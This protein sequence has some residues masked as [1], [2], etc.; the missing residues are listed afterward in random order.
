MK[1]RLYTYAMI[2]LLVILFTA[3][4][5]Q[6]FSP[7][8]TPGQALR[9]A[10]NWLKYFI[11]QKGSWGGESSASIG[12]MHVIMNDSDTLG[13][14]F[15]ILPHGY[16]LCPAYN[17]QVPILAYSTSH[18]LTFFE[19]RS[20]GSVLHRVLQHRLK[21]IQDLQDDWQR[22]DGLGM[23]PD[24][25][26]HQQ[27]LWEIYT[28]EWQIFLE[29]IKSGQTDDFGPFLETHWH[30][31]DPY[32]QMCPMGAVGRCFVGCTALATAQIMK[33]YN[34]PLSGVNNPMPSYY[35]PGEPPTV[36]GQ[37][38]T[39]DLSD[40]YDWANMLNSYGTS[41]TQIQQDAVSELCYEIGVALE[42]IYRSQAPGSSAFPDDVLDVMSEQFRYSS[43]IIGEN[44]SSYS[45]ADDW[46]QMLQVELNAYRPVHYSFWEETPTEWGHS[47]VCDGW[48]VNGDLNQIH[49]NWG[50]GGE[51]DDWYTIDGITSIPLEDYAVHNIY[52]AGTQVSGDVTGTWTLQNSPYLVTGHITVPANQSL[53]IEPGVEVIFQGHYKFNVSTNATLTAVGTEQDSI[54]FTA[55]NPTTGWWGIRFSYAN[56]LSQI[57]YCLIEYGYANTPDNFG[58]GVYINSCSPTI[59]NCLI[60]Y[61]KSTGHGGGIY[62]SNSSTFIGENSIR[63]NYAGYETPGSHGGGGIYCNNC[64]NLI[65][66]DNVIR[67][68]EAYGYGGYSYTTGAITI[69][70]SNNNIINNLVEDNQGH[71]A[72]TTYGGITCSGQL[73]I[74]N[75]TIC[76][77]DLYGIIVTGGNIEIKN[78]ILWYNYNNSTIDVQ[79]GSAVVSYSNIQGGYAGSGNI[80]SDPLFVEEFHL[81]QIAAGQ[82]LQSPC[83][84][85]GDPASAMIIGTTRTDGVQDEEVVDMGYHYPDITYPI[86]VNMDPVNPPVIIPETGGSFEYNIN[87]ENTTGSTQLANFW[88][89]VEVPGGWQFT[90]LGPVNVILSAGSSIT[91]LRTQIVPENAP[92]GVYYYFGHIGTYPWNVTNSDY[93]AFTKEGS[94]GEWTG[95]DGWFCTGEAFPSENYVL[96][97][98]KPTQFTL[99]GAYPNPFNP[100]TTIS[101]ELPNANFV[102]LAIYDVSGRLVTDLI[103]GWRD[104]GVHEVTFDGSGLASGVYLYRIEA[105]EFTAVRK[106]VLVK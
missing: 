39:V 34:W 12:P 100:T 79:S 43:D 18:G 4:N 49:I 65:I 25:I 61:C 41:A 9:A 19:D 104:S 13:Y 24:E 102:H 86:M 28:Q 63:N 47:T 32:N 85:A 53:T 96:E 27:R 33:H 52:P 84:D 5:A 66:S 48:R 62:C 21:I 88:G 54:L 78:C 94:G 89:S 8:I 2:T 46:F 74:I 82:P 68:N 64:N 91:R 70:G 55:S 17:K 72:N 93:F 16:I 50:W 60:Q 35:W 97:N 38:L 3:F 106:M 29:K 71:G 36:P 69:S 1:T 22:Y 101:F 31:N 10:D 92:G 73:S 44:R 26:R 95:P 37:T 57:K 11:D 90:A 7:T 75:N 77:N 103:N 40:P 76:N 67:D 80:N 105:G 59:K 30:Q 23:D 14:Y 87:L 42:T 83:V 56:S 15:D 58:G 45:T 99:L 81:A 51:N 98:V 20:F 6:A